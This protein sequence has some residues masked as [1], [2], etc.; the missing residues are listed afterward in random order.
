[1][2]PS[3]DDTQPGTASQPFRTLEAARDAVRHAG[4]GAGATVWLHGGR[5]FRAS[6]FTLTKEDSGEIVRKVV[7]RSSPGEEVILENGRSDG[8]TMTGAEGNAVAGCTLRNLGGQAVAIRGEMNSVLSCDIYGM[9]GGGISVNGGDRRTLVPALNF[10]RNCDIHHLNRWYRNYQLWN[11]A[12][13]DAFLQEESMQKKLLKDV[14][15]LEPPYSTEYPKLARIFETPYTKES[16][17]EE[18]NFVTTADDP[19]F[20]DGAKLDFRVLDLAAVQAKVPGFEAVPFE[21]MG[22]LPDVHRPDV[23][24]KESLAG[25]AGKVRRDFLLGAFAS[26]LAPDRADSAPYAS[27]F[28]RNFD[29]MT[30][31]IYMTST[32]RKSGEFNFARTDALIDFAQESGLKVYLHPL[33]GGAEY[34]PKWVNEGGFSKEELLQ[35]LHDRITTLLTRYQ[36]KID[37]VDV[38]NESLTGA[39]RNPDGSFAWQEKAW[40]GGEHIWLKTLGMY[41]GQRHEFPLYLVEAFR[42]ARA[43]AGPGVKLI[44]NEWSNETTNGMRGQAFLEL[45]LA[46]R[47]EGIPVDAA[48][49]QLHCRLKDGVFRD[50]LGKPFDFDAFDAMLK[51]YERAGIDVHITEFDVHLPPNPTANDFELQGGAYAGVL[52]HALKSPA[53]KSFKTWGFTDRHSWHADGQDGHPLLL[54]ERLQPKP[55]YLRQVEMLRQLGATTP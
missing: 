28:R 43:V 5:Y 10:V 8:I 40:K 26:G 24:G 27:F 35:V 21:E 32:Q 42:T 44:L 7:Y 39:G 38:V 37:Y 14:N 20:A 46:L 22:L 9:G 16:H 18:R 25:L 47:E 51:L 55:A 49:L 41:E 50:W 33:I 53:V 29:I 30:V 2:S 45:M 34:T 23:P 4:A 12:R 11:Q 1:M 48:G 36:D 31:G 3:G 52:R 6:T 13:W 15:I 19:V 54:D 17:V